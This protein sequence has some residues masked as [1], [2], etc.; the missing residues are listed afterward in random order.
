MCRSNWSN[1][2]WK[3]RMK[4]WISGVVSSLGWMNVKWLLIA[5]F[6]I[7]KFAF[8]FLKKPCIFFISFPVTVYM[9]SIQYYIIKRDFPK[10]WFEFDNA[11]WWK[12]LAYTIP[13]R[14]NA[15]FS[16]KVSFWPLFS[17]LLTVLTVFFQ[18]L[19]IFS[20]YTLRHI[21]GHHK[22][23]RWRLVIHGGNFKSQLN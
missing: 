6:L 13:Y 9:Y 7:K 12:I 19:H 18:Y 22:L 14:D 10:F 1:F 16:K 17:T 5:L 23:I 8:N 20:H 3:M 11:H 4:S 15:S 21:D 2:F